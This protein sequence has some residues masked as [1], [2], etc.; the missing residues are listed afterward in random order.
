MPGTLD[1]LAVPP[2][3]AREGGWTPRLVLSL[4]SIAV[5]LEIVSISS[6]MASVAMMPIG[7]HFKTDQIA[8][9]TT[10]YL[11]AAAVA[12]PLAGKLAD[13]HG[14]RKVFLICMAVAAFGALVS[15]VATSFLVLVIGRALFGVLIACMFL[16]FSLM[17]DVF[18]PKTL[19]LAVSLAAGGMGLM[20]IPSPFITGLLVDAWGFRSIFWFLFIALVVMIP[21]VVLSTDE[22]PVRNPARLDLVG[23]VLLGGGLAAILAGISFGPTW[24]WTDGGTLDLVVGGVVL[25]AI[26]V[27]MALR[28]TDPIVDLRFFR[29]GPMLRICLSAGLAYGTISLYATLIPI[30]S[31][32][33]AALGLGYGFSV[34]AKG[35]GLIQIPMGVGSVIGGVLVGRLLRTKFP[36]VTL[37]GGAG[38][39]LAASVVTSF[40]HTGKPEVLVGILLFGLGM[41]MTTASVPNLVIASVPQSVQASMSSMVQASQTLVASVLPVIAFAVLN[42]NVA[43]VIDGYGFYSDHGMTIA[44]LIGGASSLAAILVAMT[45][46]RRRQTI[47][48]QAAESASSERDPEPVQAA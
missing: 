9:V 2:H 36:T 4:I 16:G 24:G 18:P 5:V 3:T 33:P 14:K 23:A 38:L 6:T 47:A 40:W 43:T 22:T 31:M 17:R 11:L 32:T 7:E 8:W 45:L 41:G 25:I 15:A 10:A 34:D 26:W 39:M 27:P 30:M 21:L 12:C 1:N 46:H 29:R 35:V 48:A 28:M 42:S 37:A 44:Y 19:A 20:T 13:I